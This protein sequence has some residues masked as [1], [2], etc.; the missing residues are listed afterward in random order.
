MISFLLSLFI[1]SAFN[2]FLSE[3]FFADWE[4]SFYKPGFWILFF[5]LFLIVT[6]LISVLSSLNLIQDLTILKEANKQK[7]MQAA[8]PLVIFQFVMVV[9]LIGFALL[10]NKQMNFIKNKDLGYTS[11]NVIVIKIPQQNAKID[12]FREELLHIPGI[13]NAGTARHYPGYRLQ[14]MNFSSGDHAFPFKFGHIDQNAIET[15]NI[16][17]LR[18]FTDAENEAKDGWLINETF[19]AHLKSVYSEDQITTG[20]FPS[21]NN[22]VADNNLNQYKILGVM[23]DFH[24][25]SLHSEIENFAFM[26]PGTD[27]RFNRFVLARIQQNKSRQLIE[28]MENKLSEI[29]PG[30]PIN[31]SFLNE[32]LNR[33][34]A[35]E[36]LLMRLINA[37]SLLAILFASLGL[38]GLSIFMTE[39]R[40]KEIGIRKVNGSSVSEIVKMLNF[41]FIKWLGL[42]FIIATP[43]AYYATQRWLQNFA[44]RT[45]LSWWIFI[46]AGLIALIIVMITVSWQSFKVA[47]RNP[48]EAL[49]YE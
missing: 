43:I 3:L 1:L 45:T 16:K 19:Y 44:Y 38:T 32:Q 33:E 26:I 25:A 28:S 8:V 21:E 37:F 48:V 13:I 2:L 41:V 22:E 31:Y 7:G 20:N 17:M 46:L 42:A 49:R 29:Y 18:Y 39:K 24:Y 15:L 9:A 12:I 4:I 35:S 40:T 5:S 10:L 14:D 27:A 11:E 36:Q 30:Q 34:Y 23:R 6:V 47:R